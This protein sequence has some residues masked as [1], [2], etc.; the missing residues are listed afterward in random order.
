MV[1]PIF[2]KGDVMKILCIGDIVGEIGLNFLE[3]KMP[4]LKDT[5]KPNLI[6]VNAENIAKNG[7]GINLDSYKRLINLNVSLITMGNHT[8]DYKDIYEILKSDSRLIVPA[9]FYQY[10]NQGYKVIN[11]NNQKVLVI[12]LL[13]RIFMNLNVENPFLVVDKIIKENPAD[14]IIVDFHAETTSEKIAF[15]NYLDGRATL[16]YGTHTHV[17]T[18]DNITLPKGLLY[19]TDLGMTG[20]L[21]G[22]IGV[23]AENMISEFINGIKFNKELSQG[24]RQLNGIIVTLNDKERKIERINIYE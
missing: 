20:S 1:V 3:E 7:R 21:D 15:A 11:Y 9:N 24:R 16:V 19:L 10:H 13:G 6:I 2:K 8:F 23:K 17:P 14:Y 4:H 18:A 12:N 5:Y 22:V